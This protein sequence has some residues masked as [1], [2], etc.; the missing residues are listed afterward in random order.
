MDELADKYGNGTLKL[1][2]RETFQMHGILK[3]NMK[4][5]IQGNQ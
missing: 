5:T 3:W 4:K 2:T 1:T